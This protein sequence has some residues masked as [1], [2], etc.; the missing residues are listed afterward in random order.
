MSIWE[1]VIDNLE[2]EIKEKLDEHYKELT[3]INEN[4]AG[5]TDRI[6]GIDKANSILEGLLCLAVGMINGNLNEKLYATIQER[7]S[8][9]SLKKSLQEISADLRSSS[10]N[11]FYK[12]LRKQLQN[13]FSG[14]QEIFE[15]HAEGIWRL[16]QYCEIEEEKTPEIKQ[17]ERDAEFAES[18][19]DFAMTKRILLE[20]RYLN[21]Y[22]S[23]DDKIK[24]EDKYVAAIT[25]AEKKYDIANKAYH[26]AMD[27]YNTKVQELYKELYEIDD[28]RA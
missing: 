21:E 3:N 11:E 8:W 26:D 18:K 7:G 13:Q 23:R 28:E 25:V 4:G 10:I 14:R 9:E 6:L 27:D 20:N 19:Y 17:A 5:N 15:E 1:T 12:E 2:K 24:A 16:G 22:L